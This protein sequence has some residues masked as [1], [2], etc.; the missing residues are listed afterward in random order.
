MKFRYKK[1]LFALMFCVPLVYLKINWFLFGISIIGGCGFFYFE[2]S[3]NN[4]KGFIISRSKKESV[5]DL[6]IILSTIILIFIDAILRHNNYFKF[7]ENNIMSVYFPYYSLFLYYI[8]GI[9][10]MRKYR[11]PSTKFNKKSVFK[12]LIVLLPVFLNNVAYYVISLTG[13]GYFDFT[14]FSSMAVQTIFVAAIL[15]EIFFR[16]FLYTCVKKYIGCFKSAI[17]VS[18]VFVLWHMNIIT[19]LIECDGVINLLYARQI[20]IVFMLGIVNCYAFEKTD[21]LIV[22]IIY[23][24]LNNGFMYMLIGYLK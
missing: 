20:I 13:S 17:F 19:N 2:D 7:S 3:K 10:L 6:V 15:E 23:H 5:V 11:N 21:S 8:V 22:P 24:I 1:E 16:G 12:M 4:D 18:L 14:T 9:I